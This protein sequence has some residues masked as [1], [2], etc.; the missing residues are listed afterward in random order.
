[1]ATRSQTQQKQQTVHEK[2][3]PTPND[4]DAGCRNDGSKP[5]GNQEKHGVNSNCIPSLLN[6]NLETPFIQGSTV[7]HPN[8]KRSLD[9]TVSVRSNY[10][11]ARL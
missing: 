6:L 4:K 7:T 10:L 2:T 11:G 8:R 1:M 3:T 9:S 5:T